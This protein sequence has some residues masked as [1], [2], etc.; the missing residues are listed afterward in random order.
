[1]DIRIILADLNVEPGCPPEPAPRGIGP[2]G[3]LAFAPELAP[4]GK[5]F[6]P[7]LVEHSL[8]VRN[9]WFEHPPEQQY[10][11]YPPVP[12]H[13]PLVVDHVLIDGRSKSNLLDVRVR[14][15]INISSFETPRDTDG[16]IPG[17]R[18]MEASIRL[19]LQRPRPKLT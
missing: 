2:H 10:T 7:F 9:T 4:S 14:N 6:F 17:H 13:R 8:D 12:Y 19:K 16:A 15:D 5:R 1:M 3:R 18:L 11:F